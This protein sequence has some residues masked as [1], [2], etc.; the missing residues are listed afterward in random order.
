MV[1]AAE[2]EALILDLISVPQGL[3]NFETIPLTQAAGRVLA[4][5]V[6]GTLDIPHWDNSAMDGYAVRHDDVHQA[7]ADHPVT[8]VI[9]ETI[10]AGQAP[11]CPVEP[12]Q[13]AR[14]LT[15][16]MLPPGADTVVMQEVTE[17]QAAQ[18]TILAAPQPG[19]FVRRRGSFY[20]AG[21]PLM[22]P[23]TPLQGPDIAVLAA[24]QCDQVQVFRQPRVAI[25]STGDE[26]VNPA[27]PLQPG[28]I[29]DSNQYALAALVQAAGGIPL[30]MG[31]IPDQPQLL[32]EAIQSA[33]TQADLILSSGGVSV[34]DF[35]YVDQILTE[36]GAT[37]HLRSVAV[38][39]GKPLTVATFPRPHRIEALEAD[40]PVLY[41]GLPGNPGS[42]LVSFWRFVEPAL[43]K[44]SGLGGGWSPLWMPATTQQ[45]LKGSG[46]RETYLWGTV[47]VC[48]RGFEFSLAGGS[49][50]SGNLINLAGTNAL[51]V[52]PVGV[53]TIAAMAP[54][55]VMVVGRIMA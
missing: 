27:M 53:E 46:N 29:V 24:A 6:T 36:L 48:D 10:P 43:R 23:G 54:V 13:A 19:Q 14:I 16:S 45:G 8:L 5:T 51:A 4:T 11:T 21:G 25:L 9:S 15:G 2:A 26:L 18:V 32:A 34:G 41:F 28:Q 30:P 1:P 42:A 35:D 39:P 50:S 40:D 47:K 44:R 55:Q 31:I 7:S 52:V 3:D 22:H 12:G 33:L 37:L 49:H 20:Q 38:K 17:R